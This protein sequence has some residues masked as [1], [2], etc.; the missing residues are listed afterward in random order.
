MLPNA[1]LLLS[2]QTRSGLWEIENVIP[3]DRTEDSVKQEDIN[4]YEA[5][6]RQ[7]ARRYDD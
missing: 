2:P 6:R 3:R 1:S 7:P 4:C 5:R